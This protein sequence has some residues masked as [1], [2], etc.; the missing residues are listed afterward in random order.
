MSRVNWKIHYSDDNLTMKR[1]DRH[2]VRYWLVLALVV[3]LAVVMAACAPT[4]SPAPSP[5]N[6]TTTPR[7][8]ASAPASVPAPRYTLT[9]S[10]EPS[11]SAGGVTRSPDK[12]YYD[13]GEPV[14]LTAIAASG[15]RF[16]SWSGDVTGTSPTIQTIMNTNKTVTAIFE[17]IR[18]SLSTSASSSYG[19]I[20]SPNSG[21]YDA[22][23]RVTLIALPASGYQFDHW[24]GDA[25]GTSP[26]VAITMDGDKNVVAYFVTPC[27][28]IQFDIGG[29][30][31]LWH[32]S[33]IVYSKWLHEGEEVTGS[34]RLEGHHAKDGD[35]TWWVRVYDRLIMSLAVGRRNCQC[36]LNSVLHL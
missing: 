16:V 18:Y 20:V 36:L 22:G 29:V 14:T 21:T 30:G 7:P 5:T 9:T 3:T 34:I 28:E 35:L 24:G 15:Y 17:Q 13:S 31:D 11:P 4:S 6:P 2:F 23:T 32:S 33:W 19:G 8:S 25:S 10:V 26:T 12:A 1:N 27:E